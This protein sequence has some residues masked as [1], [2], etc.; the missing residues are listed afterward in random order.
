MAEILLNGVMEEEA[1]D[2]CHICFF[3]DSRGLELANEDNYVFVPKVVCRVV[4][5]RTI[6]VQD[7]YVKKKSL[8][9]YMS[10]KLK[11]PL[12]EPPK[13]QLAFGAAERLRELRRR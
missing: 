1:G 9:C 2:Y 13:S 6:A 5:Y 8:Q 4:D 12:T 10:G 11:G 3:T 7:W